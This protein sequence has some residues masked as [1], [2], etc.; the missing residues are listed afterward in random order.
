PLQGRDQRR[1]RGLAEPPVAGRRGAVLPAGRGRLSARP[2]PM[3]FE[4]VDRPL[5]PEALKRLLVDPAAGACVTFEG[6]VRNHNDGEPVILL[7]YEAH[8][9]I[10][11]KEGERIV[12]EARDR[13]AIT[14]AHCRHRVGRLEIGE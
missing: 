11:R 9:P 6:W 8:E 14:A 2:R 12:A 7:E 13:F 10:A 5:D 3:S 1:A 4:L